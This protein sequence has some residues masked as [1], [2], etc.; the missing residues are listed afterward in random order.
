MFVN[1]VVDAKAD[2]YLCYEAALRPDTR[3]FVVGS[4]E[5]AEFT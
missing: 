5:E 4:F 2:P 1:L 3:S